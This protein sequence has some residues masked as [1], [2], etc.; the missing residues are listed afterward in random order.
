MFFEA[1]KL[2]Y[3]CAK[4][5]VPEVLRVRVTRG[6]SASWA[7]TG[8]V[9]VQENCTAANWCSP[10]TLAVLYNLDVVASSRAHTIR[11]VAVSSS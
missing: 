4:A 7:L 5:P 1:I 6:V 11:S 3:G 10:S 9:L 8:G 2:A